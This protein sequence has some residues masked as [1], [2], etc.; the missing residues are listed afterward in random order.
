MAFDYRGGSRLSHPAAGQGRRSGGSQNASRPD[1]TNGKSSEAD[2]TN[3]DSVEKGSDNQR[4]GRP[5]SERKL[6]R[7]RHW[8]GQ[9]MDLDY[10]RCGLAGVGSEGY[11]ENKLVA[12]VLWQ[13]DVLDV[14]GE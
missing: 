2:H 14:L 5:L 7:R 13:R 1:R 10:G 3:C 6:R 4:S 11:R 8:L 12:S 9:T